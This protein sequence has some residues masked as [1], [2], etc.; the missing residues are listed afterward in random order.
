MPQRI[1]RFSFWVKACLLFV[2]A[3]SCPT[4]H[5]EMPCAEDFRRLV[6]YYQRA[7][8]GKLG[9][10]DPVLLFS[11]QSNNPDAHYDYIVHDLENKLIEIIDTTAPEFREDKMAELTATTGLSEAALQSMIDYYAIEIYEDP[12]FAG[13]PKEVWERLEDLHRA[14]KLTEVEKDSAESRYLSYLFWTT[15]ESIPEMAN[16]FG[17][18]E[19][20]LRQDLS[21]LRLSVVEEFSRNGLLDR[22]IAGYAAGRPIS[23]LA[24]ELGVGVEA[25]TFVLHYKNELNRGVKWDRQSIVPGIG[26]VS[27]IGYAAQ[28]KARGQTHSEIAAALNQLFA[29][30]PGDPDYRTQGAVAAKL[31][32]LG[33]T[34][35]RPRRYP[36]DITLPNYG[37][38]KRNGHLVL[39]TARKYLRDHYL[40]RL[41]DS[42]EALGVLPD[43][44]AKFAERHGILLKDNYQADKQSAAPPQPAPRSAPTAKPPSTV[45]TAPRISARGAERKQHILRTYAEQRDAA[46]RLAIT[47][48]AIVPGRELTEYTK[49]ELEAVLL[50]AGKKAGGLAK[51]TTSPSFRAQP[52]SAVG[53]SS[54]RTGAT[55]LK[56][57]AKRLWAEDHPGETEIPTTAE[58]FNQEGYR[59]TQVLDRLRAKPEPAD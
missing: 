44:L 23:D 55:Y 54:T 33:L 4:V 17:M 52:F 20:K 25:L 11:L 50:E 53:E 36:A 41:E 29:T 43:G 59:A 3:A 40:D 30:K 9:G 48:D 35:A 46:K 5:A 22:A 6:A 39:D 2:A 49:A 16:R 45:V 56:E 32:E 37:K 28:L 7:T 1:I 24:R 19:S 15:Q 42:A 10:E 26:T 57:Y 21:A 18:S 27:E 12:Q 31:D 34:E 14:V 8:V 47:L 13:H 51:L 58:I 38:V